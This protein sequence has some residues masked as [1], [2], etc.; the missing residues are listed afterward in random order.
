[1]QVAIGGLDLDLVIDQPAQHVVIAGVFGSRTGVARSARYAFSSAL[2]C[3]RNGTEILRSD[4]LLA[5]DDDGDI[6]RKR[7]VTGFQARRA[8]TKVINCPLSSSA[9]RATMIFRPSA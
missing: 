6:Y 5:F 1:M 9:P 8:S 2:F 7:S 3:S 4:F